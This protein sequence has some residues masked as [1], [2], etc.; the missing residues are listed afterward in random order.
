MSAYDVISPG[1]CTHAGLA[2]SGSRGGGE[3]AGVEVK[4]SW[5]CLCL[6]CGKVGLDWLYLSVIADRVGL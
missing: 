1:A 5:F 3:G 4:V 6:C 2:P